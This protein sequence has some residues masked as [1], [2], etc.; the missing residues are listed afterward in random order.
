MMPEDVLYTIS[1]IQSIRISLSIQQQKNDCKS[2]VK[3][4]Y[5]I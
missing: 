5:G 2:T 3:K 4:T 1:Y